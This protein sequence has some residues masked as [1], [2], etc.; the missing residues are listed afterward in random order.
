MLPVSLMET[1]L[2]EID[3]K[4]ARMLFDGMLAAQDELRALIPLPR[5]PWGL[6]HHLRRENR[7]WP[8][9]TGMYPAISLMNA[10]IATRGESLGDL[11]CVIG[12][13]YV[14]FHVVGEDGIRS[15]SIMPLG[16]TDNVEI[17][18]VDAMTDLF[19]RR[20]L[21]PLPFTDEELAAV[22]TT[23]TVLQIERPVRG[24]EVNAD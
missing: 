13:A 24:N 1:P 9:E 7:V 14:V 12:S 19:V 2:H 21:K 23:E 3:E 16:Q 5:V 17:D 22:E 8:I 18:Y 10:N 20:E 4:F 6:M 11:S 15:E